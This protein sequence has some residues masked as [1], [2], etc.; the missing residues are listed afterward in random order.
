MQVDLTGFMETKIVDRD[1]DP[2]SVHAGAGKEV[3]GLLVAPKV[4]ATNH[5]HFFSFRLDMDVDGPVKNQIYEM[6]VESADPKQFKQ[7][8]AR[9]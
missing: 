5:Q 6:N 3:F 7:P 8:N 9:R 1:K 4:E 2:D